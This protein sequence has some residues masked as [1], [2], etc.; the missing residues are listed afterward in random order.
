MR[1][2]LR[3]RFRDPGRE[4]RGAPFWSWNGKLDPKEL[5]RQV[6]DM[7]EHGMGGFFMHSR[8]GLETP[9]LGPEWMEAVRA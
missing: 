8:V 6:R 3:E 5:R 1:R 7:K 9:Y 2:D 4:F